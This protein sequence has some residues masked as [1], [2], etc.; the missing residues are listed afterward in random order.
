MLK[1]FKFELGKFMEFYGEGSSF[2][3][4]I[5]DEIGVKV[6]WVDGYELLV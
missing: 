5:G 3:K 6:E 2:G 1:K 4:V